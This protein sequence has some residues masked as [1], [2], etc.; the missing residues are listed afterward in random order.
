MQSKALKNQGVDF[1]CQEEQHLL[2]AQPYHDCKVASMTQVLFS[3][4]MRFTI[5][6]SQVM[7]HVD[8]GQAKALWALMRR[9]CF[10]MQLFLHAHAIY[11]FSEIGGTMKLTELGDSVETVE[12][13]LEFRLLVKVPPNLSMKSN[14][15][16]FEGL[17]SCDAGRGG[18]AN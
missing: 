1:R 5:E 9:R 8:L 4:H 2:L 13:D 6:L 10:C 17:S 16:F 7:Q 15:D 18:A 12:L 14:S 3:A 11:C